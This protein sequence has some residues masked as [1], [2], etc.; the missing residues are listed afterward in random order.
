MPSTPPETIL[1]PPETVTTQFIGP[2]WAFLMLP[3]FKGNMFESLSFGGKIRRCPRLLAETQRPAKSKQT[4][5][6]ETLPP[7]LPNLAGLER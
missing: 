6:I 4:S 1:L 5:T 7:S 3:L 2:S